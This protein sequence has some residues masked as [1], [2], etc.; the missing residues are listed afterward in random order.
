MILTGQ[1]IEHA[2]L[3]TLRAALKLE[4]K[5][6]KLSRSPSAYSILKKMGFKGS[7]EKRTT[8]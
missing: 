8:A 6:M 7:R 3:L 4:M 1:Q 5:G 2:R